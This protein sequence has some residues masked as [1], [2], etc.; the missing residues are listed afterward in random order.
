MN[1][2][3]AVQA[4]KLSNRRLGRTGAVGMVLAAAVLWSFG[5]ILIKGVQLNP[6]AIAGIRSLIATFVVWPFL[7][8]SPFSFSWD[9]ALGAVSYA[10]MVIF[11]I[12]ATKATT[13]ANAI[14]IQ[15]T[16]PVYIALF[17]GWLLK[18]K[19]RLKDWIIIAFVLGGMLLFFMD[20]LSMG[21]IGG[22]LL[23]LLSGLAMAFSTIFMRRQKDGDPL[24]NVFWGGIL[25]VL[26]TFPFVFQQMP[27]T[28]S[29]L[30][31]LLLGVFQLGLPYV[32]YAHAIK[33]ITA[34]QSTFA[35]LVEPLL[36]PL[37][38][39]FILGEVPGPM[40]L[41][42]GAVV[43]TAVSAGCI[44]MYQKQQPHTQTEVVS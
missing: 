1:E 18:E 17:G 16:A 13:A 30:S 3:S 15:Y 26:V 40:S 8:R 20:D 14:M 43:L 33:H 27:D 19:A 5:G 32:L 38:V 12:A 29:L 25:T 34:L 36:N 39:F 37:W 11:F 24:E 10:A 2:E 6:M 9:K 7:K 28:Q 35:C 41:L 23:A 4:H 22:N 42:G 44:K 21:Q 31:L